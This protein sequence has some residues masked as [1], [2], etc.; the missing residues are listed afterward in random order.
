MIANPLLNLSGEMR[1]S[2]KILPL[3]VIQ[4]E[5]DY[6]C[7]G[8]CALMLLDYYGILDGRSE[9][10]ISHMLGTRFCH[11]MPGTHPDSMVEFLRSE[12]LMVLASEGGTLELIYDSID[13]GHPVLVL[14]SSWGGHWRLVVG[15]EIPEGIDDWRR[16][17]LL[18]ADPEWQIDLPTI[19]R[20]TGITIQNARQ[21]F[22]QWYENRLFNRAWERFYV[23]ATT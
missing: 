19:D 13:D 20:R 12:G 23:L 22:K 11:P 17:R 10:E 16:N 7:G 5:T 14:D 18:F 4:Q 15:Y 8:A 1:L 9:C 6:S 21:F 3:Q 2:R